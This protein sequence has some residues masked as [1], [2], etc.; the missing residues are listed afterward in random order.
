MF[1]KQHHLLVLDKPGTS[2]D[3]VYVF[4]LDKT[5]FRKK[6]DNKKKFLFELIANRKGK[7]MD[8]KGSFLF[9]GLCQENI[10]EIP[11]LVY[12]AYNL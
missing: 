4:E 12:S 10:D 5:S 3:L 1:T 8:F 6:A 9:D 7:I 11:N 2:D